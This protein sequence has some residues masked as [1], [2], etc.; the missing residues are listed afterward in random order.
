MQKRPKIWIALM[1]VVTFTAGCG[2]YGAG[3]PNNNV[4]RGK[5]G[6]QPQGVTDVNNT[7]N[8]LL[9]HKTNRSRAKKV[10]AATKTPQNPQAV[11]AGAIVFQR[12]CASCH[13]PQGIGTTGA[14]RL[15]APSGVVSTFGDVAKLKTFI[16]T[17]MPANHPGSLDAK[18]ATTVSQ[19]VWHIAEGK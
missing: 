18:D 2:L 14:P 4:P 8:P 13:G 6:Q 16:A 3:G 11:K 17:H 19:Y 10:S 5:E 9:D 15:A 7:R 12:D 1:A